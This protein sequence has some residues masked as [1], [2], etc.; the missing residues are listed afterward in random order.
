MK[1]STKDAQNFERLK[2][3]LRYI[4][5]INIYWKRGIIF[6]LLPNH[7]IIKLLLMSI[8]NNDKK[9]ENLFF[10]KGLIKEI[11]VVVAVIFILSYFSI[12][13]KEVWGSIESIYNYIIN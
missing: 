1:P 8:Q 5:N 10:Q 3:L 6:L 11:V 12:D 2:F 9:I 13:P 4:L 7:D